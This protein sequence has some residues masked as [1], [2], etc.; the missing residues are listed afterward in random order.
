MDKLKEPVSQEVEL[1]AFRLVRK[2]KAVISAGNSVEENAKNSAIIF[3]QD[4]IATC[5]SADLAYWQQVSQ[6]IR[7][8]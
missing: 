8:L 4:K 3:V 6:M 1:F 2:Y 7:E 5:H